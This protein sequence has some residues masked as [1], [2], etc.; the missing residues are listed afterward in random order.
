MI[1]RCC[2]YRHRGLVPSLATSTLKKHRRQAPIGGIEAPPASKVGKARKAHSALRGLFNI[3]QRGQQA[4][5][6]REIKRRHWR[7]GQAPHPPIVESKKASST[8]RS[9]SA[10][11]TELLFHRLGEQGAIMNY[12]VSVCVP[13]ASGRWRASF[14]D[15]AGCEAEAQSLEEAIN[16][17]TH[18]LTQYAVALNGNKPGIPLP[19]DLRE[20]RL[21]ITGHQLRE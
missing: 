1:R 5:P 9:A 15:V 19:R 18:A 3:E 6:K 8:V 21:T 13:V 10:V 16:E 11:T 4:R 14:P 20:I 12:Y 7:P 2:Q 17:A